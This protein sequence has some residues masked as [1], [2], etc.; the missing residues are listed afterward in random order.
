MLCQLGTYAS[1]HSAH[2]CKNSKKTKLF[3]NRIITMTYLLINALTCVPLVSAMALW[4]IEK[5]A[6]YVMVIRKKPYTK[7]LKHFSVY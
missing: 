2:K 3:L 1:S 4:Q 5:Y 6:K 7:I